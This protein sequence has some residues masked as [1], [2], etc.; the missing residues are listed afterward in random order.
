MVVVVAGVSKKTF[1]SLTGVK[2]DCGRPVVS[3]IAD[4]FL[5]FTLLSMDVVYP[6]EK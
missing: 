3:K 6:F 5:A 1:Q 2:N 4:S